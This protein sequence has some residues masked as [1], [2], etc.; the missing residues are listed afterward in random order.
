MKN[1]SMSLFGVMGLALAGCGGS[2]N[3]GAH[4]VPPPNYNYNY[5]QQVNQPFICQAGL[6]QLRNAF[7]TPQCFQTTNIADACSQAGG[8]LSQGSLCRRERLIHEKFVGYYRNNGSM[9][10]DNIRLRVNLFQGESVKIYGRID[11]R[12]SSDVDWHAQLLQTQ[13][14]MPQGAVPVG[15]ASGDTSTSSA[16]ANLSIT[17]LS[18]QA[19]V[20]TIPYGTQPYPQNTTPYPHGT[21]GGYNTGVYN[22]GVYAGVY[23]G[24]NN[25]SSHGQPQDLILQLMFKG[26]IKVELKAS[27]IACED[28]R[29]NSYPCQ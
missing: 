3:T 5:N 23:G 7:G 14:G 24:V 6:I 4:P 21:Q 11:S 15:S 2:N 18:T 13:P 25:Q 26:K 19:T 29:G 22:G 28:G 12:S 9:P 17:S 16:I 8:I 10:V 1:I 20:P 27:A